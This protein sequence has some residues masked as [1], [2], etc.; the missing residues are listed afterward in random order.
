MRFIL[1]LI[2]PALLLIRHSFAEDKTEKSRAETLVAEFYKAHEADQ[3]AVF[4]QT[5]SRK[6]LDVY[7]TTELADLIWK[8]AVEA[9]GEVGVIGADP[10]FDAQD[11]EITEFSLKT[12]SSDESKAV[13][14][15]TF[16]NFGEKQEIIFDLAQ[17]KT[18]L[19][20]THI[21]RWHIADIRYADG[22]TLLGMLKA[23]LTK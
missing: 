6:P 8:D 9:D 16:K 22:R 17:T 20:N 23:G 18:S 2:L 1:W 7:F 3:A 14:T 10:L 5:K 4:N 11:T 12:R 19:N 21:L 13:I 15:A